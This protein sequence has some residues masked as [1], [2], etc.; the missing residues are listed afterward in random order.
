[1]PDT[2]LDYDKPLVLKISP[3]ENFCVIGS[4]YGQ[5]GVVVDLES[6]EI[7]L[8]ISRGDYCVEHCYWGIEFFK[9]N[10]EEYLIH[11]TD[12]NRL[13][14]TSLNT[15]EVITKRKNP[16]H[17]NPH[18][19]DY[20]HSGISI[21]PNNTWIIDNGWHW[22]PW[23]VLTAWSLQRWLENIWESEGGGSKFDITSAAYFWDRPIC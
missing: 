17:A 13:D 6:K 20:F 16:E 4:K 10:N 18:Y 19:L 8:E 12:W 7:I 15:K 9:L 3:T 5:F 2:K 23:G 1:L 14:I 21:S 11:N 22:H